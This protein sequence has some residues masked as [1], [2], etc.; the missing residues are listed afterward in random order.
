MIERNVDVPDI[1]RTSPNYPTAAG[2]YDYILGGSHNYAIEREF[3]DRQMEIMPFLRQCAIANRQYLGRA[4]RYAVGRGVRQFVDIGAGLPNA[5]QVH[6]VADRAAPGQCRTVYIDN[7]PVAH[8]LST[9]MLDKGEDCQRHHAVLADY[10]DYEN[11]WRKVIGT[12]VIDPTEPICL[13]VVAVLHFFRPEQCP[14]EAMAFYRDQLAAGSLLALSHACDELDTP[15]VAAVLR[16]Y[17]QTTNPACV[18][19]RA[20]VAAFFGDFALV[21]PGLVWT[22]QWPDLNVDLSEW[23]G[24]PAR[25]LALAGVAEKVTANPAE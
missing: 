18:R 22:P 19:T 13:L 12:G 15:T 8:T 25:S 11:L 16:N 23:D 1:L 21:D 7:E 2:V 9:I 20:E 10:F 5:G 3:G 6:D 14:E 17:D 24:N 4:V